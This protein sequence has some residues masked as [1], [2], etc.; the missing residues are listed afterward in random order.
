MR[1]WFGLRSKD[2]SFTASSELEI[3]PPIIPCALLHPFY[4]LVCPSCC[5]P[6]I[7][8]PSLCDFFKKEIAHCSYMPVSNRDVSANGFWQSPGPWWTLCWSRKKTSRK[9]GWRK[10]VGEPVQGQLNCSGA[11]RFTHLTTAPS[12]FAKRALQH[13][14]YITQPNHCMDCK[15]HMAH[16]KIHIYYA[17]SDVRKLHFEANSNYCGFRTTSR[18][19]VQYRLQQPTKKYNIG[20][21]HTF[22]RKNTSKQLRHCFDASQIRSL[23]P[24]TTCG[25]SYSEKF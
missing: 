2:L 1:I 15:E 10:W 19:E 5:I 12:V 14:A 7:A 21:S 4:H 9:E 20:E 22:R 17:S 18:T 8:A 16:T 23:M 24:V 25:R 6:A 3:S 11:A 13:D